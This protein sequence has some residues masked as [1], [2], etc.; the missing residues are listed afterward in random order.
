MKRLDAAIESF[1]DVAVANMD[2]IAPEIARARGRSLE[3]VTGMLGEE[4]GG[5]SIIDLG[6]FLRQLEN[7]PDE[8]L[9]ARDAVFAA[10]DAAVLHQVTSRATEQ[11]T[12]LNVFFPE[13]PDQARGYVAQNIAP[14]GWAKLIAAYAE[15][16]QQSEGPDGSAEF[17]S[18]TAD[19]LEIGPGGI[20]IAGQLQSGDEDNVAYAETRIFSQL[21]GR[22]ALVAGLPAYL[23]SGGRGQ[24]QGVW[25]FS[26]TTLQAG[27]QRAPA[28]AVYQAQSGGL[29]GWFRALYTAP[30]GS[31]TDVEIQVLLSSEGEIES[32]SVSDISLGGGAQAGIDLETGG[33]LTPYLIVPSSGG[34]QLEL[35]SQSVPINDKTEVSYPKLAKGTAF[36]MG[37]VVADL[38]GNFDGAFVDET[39]R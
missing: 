6:D 25:N 26:V 8:V 12:G 5:D 30:N 18:E 9:V 14:P 11:A 19:V 37:V 39:V 24:V 35:S 13:T 38:A 27:K 31:Q 33:S 36:A 7:V 22:D 3:F 23:N 29:L 32:I 34:F 16:A 2:Q 17:T 15:F 1:A 10:L 21:D 4:E 20:R 28:S